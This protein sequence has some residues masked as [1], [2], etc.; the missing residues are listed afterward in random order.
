MQPDKVWARAITSARYAR[1]RY[2]KLQQDAERLDR[3]GYA[4]AGLIVA[5][6]ALLC[7]ELVQLQ[8]ELEH[9]AVARGDPF[10]VLWWALQLEQAAAAS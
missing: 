3:R 9:I 1:A 4:G 7:E 5:R 10:I 8:D 6:C 2:A